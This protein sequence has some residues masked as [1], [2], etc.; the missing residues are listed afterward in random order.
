MNGWIEIFRG[1]NQ[2]GSNGRIYDGDHLIDRAVATFRAAEH[3]PPVVVGHPSDDSPAYGWVADIRAKTKEGAKVLEARFKELAPAFVE[4]VKSG[5]Y[6][7]RSAAFYADGRL[8]HVGFLGGQP[9]AVKGLAP[10]NFSDD[11]NVILIE[12]GEPDHFENNKEIFMEL[13]QEQLDAKIA[14]ATAAKEAELK[15]AND[16]AAAAE[17][18]FSESE[19]KRKRD[20]LNTYVD[21][22]VKDG[23][24]VPAQKKNLVSFME[25]LDARDNA[26][27][28]FAEGDAEQDLKLVDAFKKFLEAFESHPLFKRMARPAD[29]EAGGEFAD[30]GDYQDLTACV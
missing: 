19:K 8:R 13:T 29:D 28:T 21:G 14:E 12:F 11:P 1:G 23:R 30:G 6:K 24:V 25:A 22:L 7:K 27:I 17:A 15:T 2:T 20:E 4:A 18:R 16:R 5:R 26:T 10:I 3:E 9:P